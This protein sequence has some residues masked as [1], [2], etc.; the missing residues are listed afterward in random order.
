M[1]LAPFVGGSKPPANR[2][3]S[4]YP[5]QVYSLGMARIR[6]RSHLESYDGWGAIDNL[7]NGQQ[8]AS[9]IST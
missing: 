5:D 1:S 8:P 9:R 2:R 4:F 6:A 7:R 3:Q